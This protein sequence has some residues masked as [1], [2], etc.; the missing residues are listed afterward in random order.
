MT[1]KKNIQEKANNITLELS[2]KI[3]D[4]IHSDCYY[5]LYSI[6][7]SINTL[8]LEEQYSVYEIL[9]NEYLAKIKKLDNNQIQDVLNKENKLLFIS[10]ITSY[11]K[12]D[13][14]QNIGDDVLER[15]EEEA[16]FIAIDLVFKLLNKNGRNL[17]LP[18]KIKD[19]EYF[20]IE[21]TYKQENIKEIFL[22]I[23]LNL[24]TIYNYSVN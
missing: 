3:Q 15:I 16:S 24:S 19:I 13:N 9:I 23:I 10:D 18:I 20:S 2:A 22:G 4:I 14:S 7:S 21:N 8:S 11:F 6:F 1:K 17:E 12:Y 5:S